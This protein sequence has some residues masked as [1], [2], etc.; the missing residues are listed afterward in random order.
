MSQS[1]YISELL[2][3]FGLENTKT[4]LAPINTSIKLDKDESGEKVDE[5]KYCGMIGCLLYLTLSRPNIILSVGI[6]AT[7]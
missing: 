5:K 2:K 3:R 6:C 4:Y 7:F 1:K